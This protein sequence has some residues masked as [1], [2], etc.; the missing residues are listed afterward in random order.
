MPGSSAYSTQ[1]RFQNREALPVALHGARRI[2]KIHPRAAALH[3]GNPAIGQGELPLEGGIPLGLLRQGIEIGER[4]VNQFRAHG[5]RARQILDGVVI[6]EDHR[7]GQLAD[8]REA[9]ARAWA[10]CASCACARAARA[11]QVVPITP[12]MR[13]MARPAAVAT[14]ILRRLTNLAA[15]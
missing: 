1:Q 14:P 7:V 9:L 12:P 3:F 11:C 8:L 2:A 4:V 15:R 5:Y 10:F 6:L 13:V